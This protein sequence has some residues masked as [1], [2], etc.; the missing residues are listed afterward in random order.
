[1][2]QDLG[3]PKVHALFN[4]F[5]INL[6]KG[7]KASNVKP[8]PETLA[9]IRSIIMRLDFLDIVKRSVAP[10]IVG[11]EQEKFACI[12]ACFG[13]RSFQIDNSGEFSL[14]RGNFHVILLGDASTGKSDILKWIASANPIGRFIN[15]AT[16]V[17]RTALMYGS[18]KNEITGEMVTRPGII[19]QASNG[20][21]CIDEFGELKSEQKDQM[22][23]V[24]ESQIIH[25]GSGTQGGAFLQARTAIICAGNPKIGHVVEMEN[26]LEQFDMKIPLLSRFLFQ[27][28]IVEK[29]EKEPDNIT[30]RSALNHS[31]GKSL[32]K[33]DRVA[34]PELLPDPSDNN[35]IIP[36]WVFRQ[37]IHFAKKNI[38]PRSDDDGI[39]D[40]LAEKYLDLRAPGYSNKI[41]A[42]RI[43]QHLD[44]QRA[45]ESMARMMLRPDVR[46]SDVD[47][48]TSMFKECMN[49]I[50]LGSSNDG[51]YSQDMIDYGMSNS[52]QDRY[53]TVYG[54]VRDLQHTTS[55]GVEKLQIL[56]YFD[57]K[58]W[59]RSLITK[60]LMKLVHDKKIWATVD[61]FYRAS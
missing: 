34:D 58:G 5:Q 11:L 3:D 29:I 4:G 61:G 52:Q 57:K 8:A 53:R 50:M 51:I 24:L 55:N 45:S 56:N 41:A 35:I 15:C 49:R 54:V 44:L 14:H 37:W 28:L 26:P 36:K 30:I 33:I 23:E 42:I 48:V 47:L 10:N 22:R 13:G 9:W 31:S 17:S 2:A 43:R 39:I 46:Y 16:D 12:L 27:F 60:T 59:D 1:M 40:Y 19:P 18:F 7:I 25:I 32:K 38:E 20:V 21:A 6:Q